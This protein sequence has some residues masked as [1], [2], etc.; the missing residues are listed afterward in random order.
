M[1][2]KP[3]RFK[4]YHLRVSPCQP[5]QEAIFPFT[6][7]LVSNATDKLVPKLRIFL[8]HAALPEK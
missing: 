7:E 3:V 1:I 5:M 4:G 6:H 2:H 8:S